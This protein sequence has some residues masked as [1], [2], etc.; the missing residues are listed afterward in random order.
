M[1]TAHQ[2]RVLPAPGR[3]RQLVTL[4]YQVVHLG[5]S[6]NYCQVMTRS[7]K[8]QKRRARSEPGQIKNLSLSLT[9]MNLRTQIQC[10]YF[11]GIDREYFCTFVYAAQGAAEMKLRIQIF[12]I[13]FLAFP[14]EERVR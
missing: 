5:E 3:L 11:L 12:P 14:G 8:G 10:L 1:V 6:Q 4:V 7:D 13:I 2:K 9:L